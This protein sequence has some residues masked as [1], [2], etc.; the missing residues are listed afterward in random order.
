MTRKIGIIGMGHVGSTVAHALIAQGIGDDYVF[1]DTNVDK[2]N[3]DM[4]DFQDALANATYHANLVLN[5]YDALSDADV[6]ISALGD[7]SLQNN[8]EANRFAELPFTSKEVYDVSQKLKSSGFRGILI[9]VTNPVDAITQLYQEYT[10][11]PK[12]RVIGTG[13]LLDTARMKRVLGQRLQVDPRSIGGYN[14]GEHGNSQFVA[15]SQVTVKGQPAISLLKA[16]ELEQI[17]EGSLKGGHTVFFGKKYTSYGIATA[18][19]R[20]VL[21]VLNDSHE[22]LPVSTFYESE[23]VYLG[24]P[25]I[26]GR[27]GIVERISLSLS[28]KEEQQ[29]TDSAAFIRNYLKHINL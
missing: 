22:L 25:A 5:D 28:P 20:I 8:K 24:Y 9:V 1:I 11:F 19:V 12:S 7:I 26:I 6:V 2:V 27:V 16:E 15:W 18:A 4:I 13:T 29:L 3:A 14:L 21:T 10:Q 23:G 17:K